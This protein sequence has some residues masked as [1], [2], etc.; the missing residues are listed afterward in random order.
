MSTT[1]PDTETLSPPT[2]SKY[3]FIRNKPPKKRSSQA[4]LEC[5]RRKVRC[6][7]VAQKPA[8]C[9]NCRLDGVTC[10][11]G[12][13]KRRPPRHETVQPSPP[14]P[15]SSI[16]SHRH[17]HANPEVDAPTQHDDR[18]AFDILSSPAFAFHDTPRQNLNP[19]ITAPAL[20]CL[21]KLATDIN[22]PPF[23]KP[24]PDTLQAE[25][26]QYLCAKKC[27]DFPPPDFE[28]IIFQRFAEFVHPL[29]PLVDVPDVLSTISGESPTKISLLLYHTLIGAGLAAVEL[30]EIKRYGYESKAAA[31]NN[32]YSK[33][34]ALL[35]MEVEPDRMTTCQ[36]ALL[37]ISWSSNNDPKDGMHWT[38]IAL[39]QAY[40]IALQKT[41]NNADSPL[42]RRL[43]WTLVMKE[44]DVCLSMGKPPRI[45]ALD[46]LMLDHADFGSSGRDASSQH[47]LEAAC[48]EKV[49]LCLIIHRVLR[50][51][52]TVDRRNITPGA[53]DSRVWQMD[54]ELQDWK[55]QA[56][57][58]LWR[59]SDDFDAKRVLLTV[60]M[61]KLS[62]LMAAI[63]LHKPEVPIKKWTKC[64]EETPD[65][66][67][68]EELCRYQAHARAMRRAADD[69]T[70]I[71][72][73]L[74]DAGLT[75]VIPALGVATI[76]AAVSVHLLDARSTSE[77]IRA[78][79]LQ[80]LDACLIVLREVKNIH[81][82]AGEVAK[83]VEGAIRA[84]RENRSL[85]IMKQSGTAQ[86]ICNA[87]PHAEDISEQN[88]QD[89]SAANIWIDPSLDVEYLFNFDFERDLFFE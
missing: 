77:A 45:M 4:C 39:T 59:F 13:R 67:L 30:D 19:E 50:L 70:R 22:L 28:K 43:W 47:M 65:L 11:L 82:T 63:M 41:A 89:G 35:D 32:F 15:D 64:M 31:R 25:D 68:D 78:R 81:Y 9:T 33:A 8:S 72:K 83:I 24:F 23:I 46:Q 58:D 53:Q 73:D 75:S 74:H 5:R 55:H 12:R 84:V 54:S 51:L 20:S 40:S 79:S 6:D 1:Q 36:A 10:E 49:K 17:F 80:Q 34:K 56:P 85:E 87:L 14:T 61:V 2:G 48:I 66:Y 52:H 60:S 27:F 18:G 62:Y 76:C 44:A 21:A 57:F 71:H 29:L 3:R 7:I 88:G 86:T 16:S 42:K 26:W 38:G 37:F 69:M